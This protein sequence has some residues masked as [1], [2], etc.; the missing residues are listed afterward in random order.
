[1]KLLILL[2]MIVGCSETVPYKIG[3]YV[4]HIQSNCIGTVAHYSEYTDTYLLSDYLCRVELDDETKLIKK[5]IQEVHHKLLGL[6]GVLIT[7]TKLEQYKKDLYLII[8]ANQTE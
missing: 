4:E 3:T 2:F 7:D 8:K 1:M 6:I 5:S